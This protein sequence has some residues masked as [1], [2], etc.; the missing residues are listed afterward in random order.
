MNKGERV[1]G[2]RGRVGSSRIRVGTRE[3]MDLPWM[4]LRDT[5]EPS[6]ATLCSLMASWADWIGGRLRY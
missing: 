6:A 4:D 3:I 2:E 1:E 5:P